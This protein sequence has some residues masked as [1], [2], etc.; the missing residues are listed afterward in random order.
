MFLERCS[1]PLYK[2]IRR[3]SDGSPICTGDFRLSCSANANHP[4]WLLTSDFLKSLTPSKIK[5]FN[6][7]AFPKIIFKSYEDY[8]RKSCLTYWVISVISYQ[9]L[10]LIEKLRKYWIFFFLS[11]LKGRLLTWFSGHLFFHVRIFTLAQS[12]LH[13]NTNIVY[14]VGRY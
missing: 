8:W 1:N 3:Q 11:A 2:N 14:S 7:S 4:Y 13:P 9:Y 10:H 6:C 12:G 5:F